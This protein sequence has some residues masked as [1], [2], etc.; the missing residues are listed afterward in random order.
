MPGP[1]VYLIDFFLKKLN[2]FGPLRQ[3]HL[4][5]EEI[6]LLRRYGYRASARDETSICDAEEGHLLGLGIHFVIRLKE[7]L[8]VLRRRFTGNPGW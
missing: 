8:G 1:S 3:C 6:N 2:H 7:V 5:C 4:R